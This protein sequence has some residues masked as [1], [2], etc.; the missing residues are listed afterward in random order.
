MTRTLI[1]IGTILLFLCLGVI[2][3]LWV[4][5]D[6]ASVTEVKTP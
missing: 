2:G 3:I 6:P 4:S 5:I 1:A